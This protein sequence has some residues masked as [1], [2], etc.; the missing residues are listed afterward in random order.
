MA[1]RWC[2]VRRS[3]AKGK[4]SRN[5]THIQRRCFSDYGTGVYGGIEATKWS[6]PRKIRGKN[7]AAAFKRARER[8]ARF[9]ARGE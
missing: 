7:R 1:R 8:E 2:S 4:P 5:G 9:K 3:T 6:K